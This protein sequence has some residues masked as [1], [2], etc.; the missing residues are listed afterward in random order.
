MV[1]IWGVLLLVVLLLAVLLLI[2]LLVLGYR[3]HARVSQNRANL[4]I[5]RD[6]ANLDLQMISHQVQKVQTQSLTDDSASL[7]DSLPS[8]FRA[9]VEP[10]KRSTSLRE[11]QAASFPPG[12]PSSSA[13]ESVAE[14]EVTFRSGA[15]DTV[16]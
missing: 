12:P 15:A 4:R 9:Y 7:P 2:V 1:P 13:G 5:S 14:Q 11:A 8:E 6:R 10:A 3:R 16:A